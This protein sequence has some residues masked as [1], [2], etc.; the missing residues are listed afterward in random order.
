MTIIVA[1][2]I[3]GVLILVHEYGHYIAAVKN[4]IVVEEFAIGMGPVLYSKKR[5]DTLFSLR[6]VPVGGFCKMLG[7]DGEEDSE[8][9]NAYNNKSV[10]ARIMVISAGSIMNFILSF[11][12]VLV[13]LSFNGLSNTTINMVEP[14]GPAYTAGILPGDRVT[15]IDGRN[16]W[17]FQ[18]I[19]FALINNGERPVDVTVNRQGETFTFGMTPQREGGQYRIGIGSDRYAGFLAFGAEGTRAGVVETITS[20]YWQIV[21]FVRIVIFSLGELFSANAGLDDIAGPVGIVNIIGGAVQT[22]QTISLWAMVTQVMTL[23]A[24]LSANLAVLNLLPFPALDGGRLVFLFIE[25]IRGKPVSPQKEGLVHA[26]GFILLMGL[27]LLV[28]FNDISQFFR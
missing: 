13:L 19:S 6:A 2:L 5:G 15:V 21:H 26:A 8:D 3:F 7:M 12:L 11:V 20:S 28:T 10:P 9:Q 23:A 27:I 22:A 17:I 24:L 18:D 4:G 25:G 14:G 1:V 16:V